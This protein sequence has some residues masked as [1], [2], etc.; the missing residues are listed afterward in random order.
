MQQEMILDTDSYLEVYHNAG[1][2]YEFVDISDVTFKGGLSESIHSW[3]RLTPSY[4]PELV[5]FFLDYFKCK[6]KHKI[7]DPFN[8]KGTTI[9][10]CQKRI[11][12][13]QV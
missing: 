4:S 12:I 1:L 6:S 2:P 13:Q 9:I 10:E 3:Y 5:R 7:L 8:G 11:S